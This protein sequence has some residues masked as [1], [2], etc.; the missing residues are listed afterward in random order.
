MQIKPDRLDLRLSVFRPIHAGAVDRMTESLRRYG[1]LTPVS[2]VDTGGCMVLVDGFKRHRS[3]TMLGLSFLNVSPM[4]VD[5][6]HAKALVYLLNRSTGFSHLAEARL[7]QDLMEVEGL[8]QSETAILLERHKSWVARRLL[9]FRSLA[10][11]AA[12]TLDLSLIPGGGASSLARL[13]RCNQAEMCSSIQRHGLKTNEIKRLA[14]LWLK[15]G[16]PAV[17]R[18]LLDS[19]REALAIAGTGD[20]QY[21]IDFKA[22]V[23][24]LSAINRRL[25]KRAPLSRSMPGLLRLLEQADGE[26]NITRELIQGGDHEPTE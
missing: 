17:R 23:K 1:Q 25:R 4:K 16:D 7:I 13:P 21:F 9:L 12:Q 14:D 15:A 24:T 18:S 5:M 20:R 10:P 6:G 22:L 8:S 3:A 2:A 11:E 19:P 26:M